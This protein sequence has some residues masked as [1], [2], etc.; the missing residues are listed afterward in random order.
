MGRTSRTPRIAASL[1]LAG[2]T[3]S[4]LPALAQQALSER[5]I[6]L[7]GEVEQLNSELELLREEQRTVLAGLNAQR[8]E[9]SAS[10]DRQ[11]LLAR[12]AEA[13][14]DAALEESTARGAEAGS[15]SP[16]LFSAIDQLIN[17][18]RGGLPF[19][20]EERVAA[21]EALRGQINNGSMPPAR[22]ANRLWAF[23]E[24]ELRLTR[25]T[26]LHNQTME[27][28]G[29]RVLAEVV[30]VGSMALYFRTPDGRFGQAVRGGNGWQFVVAEPADA[31]RQIADLFEA[32]RK[33]IKQGLFTLPQLAVAGGGR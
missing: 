21:L 29:E 17:Q 16:A 2:L 24:D 1:L 23:Y 14:R 33:Q 12:D 4:S 3:A 13:K 6:T 27:V 9:L 30:K 18:I 31:Q 28:G 20:I 19:K 32:Q 22:A 8:A 15:L 25:E 26:G 10:V 7:R 5:L 11:Q